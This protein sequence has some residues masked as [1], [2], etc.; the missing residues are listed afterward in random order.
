MSDDANEALV[1][2]INLVADET[3]VYA[4]KAPV[5]TS[6]VMNDGTFRT[7]TVDPDVELTFKGARLGKR[8]QLIFEFTPVDARPFK[9]VEIDEKKIGETIPEFEAQIARSL[10]GEDADDFLKA[11]RAFIRQIRSQLK[12]EAEA[13]QQ[14]ANAKYQDNPNWGSF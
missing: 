13:D 1:K 6:V 5:S 14:K 2:A 12:K 9:Q 8:T 7:K 3:L 10:G 11:K 4:V